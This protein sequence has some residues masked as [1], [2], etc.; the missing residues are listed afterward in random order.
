MM[1][2]T[3]AKA[4][5]DG[6]GAAL[7]RAIGVQRARISRLPEELDQSTTDRVIGAAIRLGLLDRLP[8]RYRHLHQATDLLVPPAAQS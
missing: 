1:T 3:E 8:S 6:N 7:G 5:F 2:K 4:I